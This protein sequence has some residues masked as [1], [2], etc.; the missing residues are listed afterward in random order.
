M[1]GASNFPT[2]GASS[3]HLPEPA[4]LWDCGGGGGVPWVHA[5]PRSRGVCRGVR[6]RRT[7]AMPRAGDKPLAV[8][9]VGAQPAGQSWVPASLSAKVVLPAPAAG[10]PGRLATAHVSLV[11]P[12][13]A[14][15]GAALPTS[16]WPPHTPRGVPRLGTALQATKPQGGQAQLSAGHWHKGWP[17]QLGH[18]SYWEQSPGTRGATGGGCA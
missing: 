16:H 15:I 14:G 12:V 17:C 8:L 9:P 1:P 7:E 6:G 13:A 3:K 5:H 4:W 18:S 2:P 11:L 10:V